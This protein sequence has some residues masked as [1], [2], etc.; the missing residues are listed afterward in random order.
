MRPFS[1]SLLK[2]TPLV[3]AMVCK[4]DVAIESVLDDGC[5][6][7]DVRRTSLRARGTKAG[8]RAA[9]EDRWKHGHAQMGAVDCNRRWQ[10]PWWWYVVVY[11]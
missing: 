7:S 6:P 1:P 5:L 3:G 8:A 4:E 10:Q 2:L 11:M 9:R